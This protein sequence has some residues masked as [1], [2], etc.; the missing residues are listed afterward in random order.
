MAKM[1]TFFSKIASSSQLIVLV[2]Q[3]KTTAMHKK[4]PKV[5]FQFDDKSVILIF[6]FLNLNKYFNTKVYLMILYKLLK[7]DCFKNF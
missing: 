4:Y 6:S 5:F 3:S 7:N 1:V 2:K